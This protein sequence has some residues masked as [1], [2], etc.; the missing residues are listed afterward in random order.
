M[1]EYSKSFPFFL[2]HQVFV[3]RKK[4]SRVI[5]FCSRL[6]SRVFGTV[7]THTKPTDEKLIKKLKKIHTEMGKKGELII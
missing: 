4:D 3:G 1:I 7:A 2:E 5:K 6:E